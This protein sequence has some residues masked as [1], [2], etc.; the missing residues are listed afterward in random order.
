MH[1]RRALTYVLAVWFVGA[2]CASPA[3][4]AQPAEAPFVVKE[5]VV[6]DQLGSQHLGNVVYRQGADGGYF[7]GWGRTPIQEW[8]FGSARQRQV[9]LTKEDHRYSNGGAALDV[10]RDGVQEIVVARGRGEAT[11]D[12]ELYW[13]D[14]VPGEEHW[15]EHYIADS[16]EE[17]FVAPHDVE[18][19]TVTLDTGE[20][21]RGVVVNVGR[22]D[23]FFFEI[24][25]DPTEPWIRHEIG[26]FSG[27]SQSG[28]EIVDING[29]GR[30][31]IVSGMFWIEMPANPRGGGWTFHRFG[32]WDEDNGRWGGMIKHGVA[33]FDGDGDVEIVA[34]EAEIPGA[35]LALFDR[36]RADGTDLWRETL[37]EDDL[38][39]PHSLVVG[40]L[41]VDGRQDF[42]VGEMTAAGWNYPLNPNPHIYGY[43]NSGGSFERYVID[44]GWGVHEMRVL[45]E[46]RNGNLIIYAADEIQP[47]KFNAMNTHLSYWVIGPRE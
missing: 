21:V 41:D 23:V 8:P 43:V 40:D 47:Q 6:F 1:A 45:P 44:E 13:F 39:A 19:L 34:A 35:R 3:V 9:V 25:D 2:L 14:E 17:R 33:D 38:Y 12:S 16:G 7:V 31:D 36:K 32:T 20:E 5:H 26:S 27:P 30:K 18:P 24:P 29:D 10:D 11:E 28:M 42:V 15:E 22:K 46:R 4:R 37:L